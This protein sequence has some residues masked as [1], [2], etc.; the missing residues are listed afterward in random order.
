MSVNTRKLMSHKV[1][2][3]KETMKAAGTVTKKLMKWLAEKGYVE[4][5]EALEMAEERASEAA[6]DLPAARELSDLLA[7]Y[8]DEHVPEHYSRG[9]QRCYF[10]HLRTARKMFP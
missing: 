8:V 3:A 10:T 5:T 1:I 2:A 6:D 7:D 9:M 4:D